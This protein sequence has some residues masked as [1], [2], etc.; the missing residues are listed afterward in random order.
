MIS[1]LCSTSDFT[2][3]TPSYRY[4]Q[5]TA[6]YT[7][8]RGVPKIAVSPSCFLLSDLVGQTRNHIKFMLHFLHQSVSLL[9]G[10]YSDVLVLSE[11]FK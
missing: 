7:R 5:E 9:T 8:N 3:R 6:I 2:S 10:L 4:N 1:N 11:T